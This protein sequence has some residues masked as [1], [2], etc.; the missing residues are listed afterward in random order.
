MPWGEPMCALRASARPTSDSGCGGWPTP[1]AATGDYQY[2]SGDHSKKVLNLSG[3]A[4]LAGWPTPD[5]Q[6][7]NVT[8]SPESFLA[9][10][11]RCKAKWGNNG[12]GL[13]LGMAAQLAGWGTPT[14]RDHKDAASTLKNTPTK[15]LLARQALGA[16]ASG[17]PSP[18]ARRGALRPG[19][20]RWLMGY[21]SVWGCCGATGIASVRKSRR[22][23]S[24]RSSTAKGGDRERG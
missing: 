24:G 16:I 6:A 2:S 1:K 20:S 19:H 22:R 5:G 14:Q 18:T 23:S 13:T 9:R 10:R 4:Q 12:F 8:E 17:C 7:M 11:A 3:V 15:A 21:P